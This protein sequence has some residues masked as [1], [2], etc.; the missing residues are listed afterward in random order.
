[1]L[2]SNVRDFLSKNS[3][4]TYLKE[5]LQNIPPKK[6]KFVEQAVNSIKEWD[7]AYGTSTR[8]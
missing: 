2:L 4:F 1:M 6:R 5:D 8:E 3:K 7:S